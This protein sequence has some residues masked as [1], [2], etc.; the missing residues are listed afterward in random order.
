MIMSLLL[1][2]VIDTD[3]PELEPDLV[4]ADPRFGSK[5]DA[6]LAPLIEKTW[7]FR[8]SPKPSP[9]AL[10]VTTSPERVPDEMAYQHSINP[11]LADDTVPRA[12]QF[13]LLVSE[14]L[15]VVPVFPVYPQA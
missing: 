5:G 14:M 7:P 1:V 6:E 15:S 4:T 9:G 11:P 3:E 12:T 2:V 10:K 13:R 8:P